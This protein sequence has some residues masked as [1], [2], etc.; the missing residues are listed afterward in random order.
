MS[1]ETNGLRLKAITLVTVSGT[2]LGKAETTMNEGKQTETRNTTIEWIMTKA[3]KTKIFL[4]Q[5]KIHFRF[6]EMMST[7]FIFSLSVSIVYSTFWYFVTN[8]FCLSRKEQQN[9]TNTR[10]Q[11]YEK[12]QIIY[13]FRLFIHS[14]SRSFR[15]HFFL[16]LSLSFII[17]LSLSL[18]WWWVFH[19]STVYLGIESRITCFAF[20]SNKVAFQ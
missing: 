14:L 13:T 3:G 19:L 11:I 20:L 12:I 18:F 8:F 5:M 9:R 2:Y 15:S 6:S 7:R 17:F 16:D 10:S 4:F 1:Q